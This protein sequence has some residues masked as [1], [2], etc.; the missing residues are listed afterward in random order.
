MVLGVGDRCGALRGVMGK[1]VVGVRA[2]WLGIFLAAAFEEEGEGGGEEGEGGGFGGG[3]G[4]GEHV[5]EGEVVA[6]VGG[7]GV[8]GDA[9]IDHVV[10]GV[11]RA[12]RT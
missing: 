4:V 7:D 9:E 2:W 8:E 10:G 12:D 6:G 5:V 3:G 1:F 11:E